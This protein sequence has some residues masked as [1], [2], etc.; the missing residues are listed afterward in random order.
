MPT[1][2]HDLPTGT[3]T[4]LFTD[5]EGST[6]LTRQLG[7]A[8]PERLAAHHRVL[9]QAIAGH[10]G[11]VV[12]TEGDSFFAVFPRARDAIAAAVDAQRSCTSGA[13]PPEDASGSAWA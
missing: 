3:L 8:Y 4:F 13:G 9:R 5:I 1:T 11:T 7:S 10:D 6:R 12:S 2:K